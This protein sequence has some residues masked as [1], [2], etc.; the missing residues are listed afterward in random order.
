MNR[1]VLAA[2]VLCT[3]V[4]C[5]NAQELVPL[6]EKK[7]TDSLTHVLQDKVTDSIKAR[8]NYLLSYYWRSKDTLKSKEYLL[9]GQQLGKNFPFIKALYYFYEGQLYF[10]WNMAKASVSFDRAQKELAAFQTKEA[11]L[12]R[13]AAWFNYGLMNRQTKGDDFAVDIALNKA[14]PLATK[15]GDTQKV[16]FY[17]SQLATMLMYNSQFS[18]AEI[19]N[20]KAIDLLEAESKE[21]PALLT[22]YLSATSNY[23]YLGKT[24]EAKLV[25]DKAKKL[26]EPYP[27][28]VSYP[29][30]YYNE[31]LYYTAKNNFDLAVSSLDKGIVLARKYHQGQLLQMLIFRKYNIL[32]EQKKYQP[33]KA[34]L[35]ALIKEGTLTAD[36]NNRKTLYGHLASL[37]EKLGNMKE[38]YTWLQAYN[39]LNDSLN[40]HQL[41]EKIN[42]LEIKFRNKENQQKIV[43]LEAEKERVALSSKNT[44]L[45][46]WFLVTVCVF[47]LIMGIFIVSYYIQKG[48]EFEQRRKLITANA[49]L[50]GEEKERRRVAQELH[51]GLGGMLAGVKMN[52]S[53][54]GGQL[55]DYKE[56]K[57]FEKIIGQLDGS[58]HELRQIARNMMPDVLLRFGLASAL[59]DL[60]ESVSTEQVKIEFQ[61]FDVND[62]IPAQMQLGIYRIVQELLANV[63]R[64]AEASNALLQC[65]QNG[66]MFF[67]TVE[68]NGKGFDAGNI[69][70]VKGL[71][72]ASI[73]NRV[74]LLNGKMSIESLPNEGSTF[75]IELELPENTKVPA[76]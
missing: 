50:E 30:Y 54:W 44:R 23:V 22:A 60:C 71:G 53:G 27:E 32:L 59:R 49:V 24:D 64:H 43:Q 75:Y 72:L 66:A 52:L 51:D 61:S 3:A 35:T 28:S 46:N 69:D 45:V 70:Q 63:F 47:L 7:Y 19:Y 37:N 25:L 20:K 6:N 39:K 65:S 13:S 36:V 2:V 42:A 40:D 41:K 48:K 34:F 10:T 26:I 16:A 14:I 9:K 57:E 8:T 29:N 76:E 68:D 33:A 74:N 62:Q 38:A 17:Y 11:Y 15:A 5:L 31:G 55:E 67:I 58:V 12:T 1:L 4:S 21:S 73:Q 56:K 18:K